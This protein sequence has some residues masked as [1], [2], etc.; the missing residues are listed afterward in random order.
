MVK[1]AV[2]VFPAAP[3]CLGQRRGDRTTTCAL[4]AGACCQILPRFDA[5]EVWARLIAREC[6]G[7]P[8]LTLFMA[9]PTIYVKLWGVS[10]ALREAMGAPLPSADRASYDRTVASARAAMGEGGE[11]TPPRAL[12]AEGFTPSARGPGV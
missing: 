2:A 12:T 10:E 5:E 9:V 11:A 7:T 8:P 6:A 3:F 1:I 4:W